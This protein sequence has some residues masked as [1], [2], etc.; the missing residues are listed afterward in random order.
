MKS[1]AKTLQL[2]PRLGSRVAVRSS[3]S[4]LVTVCLSSAVSGRVR[5]DVFKLSRQRIP[6][7][8]TVDGEVNLKRILR[9]V[10]G[11]QIIEV[12]NRPIQTDALSLHMK[13]CRSSVILPGC[14]WLT[15][16][17]ASC[18]VT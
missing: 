16:H 6:K 7:G 2:S 15:T 3:D 8:Y 11:Q 18:T 1:V 17:G 5:I 13:L 9:F 12:F 14:R 10:S 4:C